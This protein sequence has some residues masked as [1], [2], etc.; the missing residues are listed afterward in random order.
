MTTAEL[1]EL[2][3]SHLYD[4]AEAAPHPNFL[5]SVNDFAP[6]YGVTDI[7]ELQAALHYLG[8][9]G[10]IILA[11]IDMA[12]GI[13]AGITIEGS[14]FVEKGGETGI[15]KK[16]RQDPE[17][18][19]RDIPV[20]EREAPL[21]QQISA[22]PIQKQ[23]RFFPDRALNALLLDIEDFLENDDMLTEEIRKDLRSDV[24]TLKIQISRNI[25]NKAVIEAL[26]ADLSRI[27]SIAPLVTG[28]ACIVDTYLE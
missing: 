21:V 10:L 19:L 7:G 12:S 17:S 6:R 8:D 16:Y 4:L 25:K 3:L 26:L 13:S 20:S 23:K 24:A 14:V 18:F 1:A 5:F 27:P 2:F 9:R 28:L 11:S 15:I 22:S